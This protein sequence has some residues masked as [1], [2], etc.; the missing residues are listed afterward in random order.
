MIN[1]KVKILASIDSNPQYAKLC[2]QA[3][4]LSSQFS[5]LFDYLDLEEFF[6]KAKE[7]SQSSA[8]A[9]VAVSIFTLAMSVVIYA[10]TVG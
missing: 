7:N 2:L 10:G 6:T 8:I 4:D 5:P 9:L 3:E 1:W